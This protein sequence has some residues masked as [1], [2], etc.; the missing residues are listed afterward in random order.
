[1][2]Q[3]DTLAGRDFLGASMIDEVSAVSALNVRLSPLRVRH[4]TLG[5]DGE[6]TNASCNTPTVRLPQS[7]GLPAPWEYD[8]GASCL[9]QRTENVIVLFWND[10]GRTAETTTNATASGEFCSR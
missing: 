3:A 6:Q 8:Y 10:C 4:F 5:Q 1:M 9:C 2:R 7:R